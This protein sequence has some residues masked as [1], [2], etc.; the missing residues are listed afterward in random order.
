MPDC[1]TGV[2]VCE[3]VILFLMQAEESL[4]ISRGIAPHPGSACYAIM[5]QP[6]KSCLPHIFWLAGEIHIGVYP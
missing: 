1:C 5:L 2:G 6:N 3:A 4:R